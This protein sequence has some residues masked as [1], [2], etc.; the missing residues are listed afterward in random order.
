MRKLKL[1]VQLS[2]D[3]FAADQRG[4]TE[5]TVWNW[6]PK[7]NWDKSLQD[8]HSR[9]QTSSDTILLGKRMAA[10]D[11]SKYWR[12]IA[13]SKKD[14]QYKFA[15]AIVGMKRYVFSKKL[16]ESRWENTELLK[17]KPQKEGTKLKKQKG[18]DMIVYGGTSFVSSLI[19][20]DLIDEYHL[21]INP[22]ILG[23]GK[24]IFKKYYRSKI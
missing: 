9:L 11:F 17:R 16:K 19:K 15:S 4:K 12:K 1:E 10:G 5:W 7:W 8:F 18:K 22:T 21:L 23:S 13:A 24:P 14:A 2:I 6:E 20:E 3:G